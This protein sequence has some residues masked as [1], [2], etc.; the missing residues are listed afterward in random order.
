MNLR[1]ELNNC[2]RKVQYIQVDTMSGQVILQ[3]IMT[4]DICGKPLWTHIGI[5]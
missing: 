2:D 4:V 3:R 1:F 5:F